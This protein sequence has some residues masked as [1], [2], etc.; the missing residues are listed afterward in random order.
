MPTTT[1]YLKIVLDVLASAVRPTTTKGGPGKTKLSSFI[2]EEIIFFNL[3]KKIRINVWKSIYNNQLNF[4]IPA[5][6]F[7]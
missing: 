3:H 6:I 5:I 4:C 7:F 2:D 1:F